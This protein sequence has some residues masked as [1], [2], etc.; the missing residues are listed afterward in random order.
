M[1]LPKCF[2]LSGQLKS[3]QNE[4]PTQGCLPRGA[5]NPLLADNRSILM[6]NPPLAI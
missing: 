4:P 6:R 1:S 5:A 3:E 2:C